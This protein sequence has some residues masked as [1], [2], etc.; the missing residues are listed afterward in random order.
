MNETTA[1][2]HVGEWEN[3]VNYAEQ[4]NA[5]CQFEQKRANSK[6]QKLLNKAFIYAMAAVLAMT[7]AR[8]GWLT[9][10]VAVVAAIVLSCMACYAAG[11]F[12]ATREARYGR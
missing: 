3:I 1:L 10:W 7:M 6:L 11:K 8:V 12:V 9:S 5:R 2:E 4:H